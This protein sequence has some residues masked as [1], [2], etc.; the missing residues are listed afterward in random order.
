MTKRLYN[1]IACGRVLM[2]QKHK[3]VHWAPRLVHVKLYDINDIME[4]TTSGWIL[5]KKKFQNVLE[6]IRNDIDF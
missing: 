6:M 3:K 5:L 1:E 4:D 2:K